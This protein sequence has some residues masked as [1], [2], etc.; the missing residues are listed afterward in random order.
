[1]AAADRYEAMQ[2]RRTG[3]SGPLLP[4]V[5]LGLWHNFGHGRPLEMQGTILLRALDLGITNF[6]LVNNYGPP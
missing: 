2:F 1:M 6:D 5:S 3:R 4:A